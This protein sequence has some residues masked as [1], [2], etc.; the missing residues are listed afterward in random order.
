MWIT[1]TMP[2][3][4]LF[5]L[6]LRGITLPGAVDGIRAYLS[7][8]FHRLCESSVSMPSTHGPQSTCTGRLHAMGLLCSGVGGPKGSSWA[9]I[10]YPVNVAGVGCPTVCRALQDGQ[11]RTP[12]SRAHRQVETCGHS[13]ELNGPNKTVRGADH[14]LS[15]CRNRM[16]GCFRLV[17][18][19]WP[20]PSS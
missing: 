8:D 16:E 12:P 10:S 14:L 15:I 4:V 2:Y 20:I 18:P 11:P 7:V 9:G 5:A 1:A 13:R 17:S 19:P 6:L 3:V